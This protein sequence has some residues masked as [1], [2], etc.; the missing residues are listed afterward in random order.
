MSASGPECESFE[1]A[2]ARIVF[3]GELYNRAE[4]RRELDRSGHRCASGLAGEIILRSWRAWGDGCL[5]RFNGEWSFAI[6]DGLQ[7]RLICSRDRFGLRPFYYCLSNGYLIFGSDIGE[8]ASCPLVKKEPDPEAVFDYLAF[9]LI[10]RSDETF[11]RGVRELPAGCCLRMSSGRPPDVRRYYEPYCNLEIGEFDPAA[12]RGHATRLRELLESAVATRLTPPYPLGSLLSG[13]M[14]SSSIAC[15]AARADI[16]FFSILWEQEVPYID[17]IGRA[18]GLAHRR[19]PATDAAKLSWEDVAGAAQ[20]CARGPLRSSTFFGEMMIL[21]E[22]AR[23]GVRV[24]FDGSGGDELLA[25]YPDRY[26]RAFLKQILLSRDPAWF[27]KE[28]RIFCSSG[29]TEFGHR[30]EGGRAGAQALN[31]FLRAPSEAQKVLTDF[32][33]LPP[34]TFNGR[35]YRRYA[36]REPWTSAST[37]NIQEALRTD[38]FDI[39]KTL[40]SIGT[41]TYRRPFL[42]HRVVEHVLSLPACYKLHDG[43]TKYLL[44]LAMSD[45][46]PK[47]GCWRREKV[48]GTVPADVW[49]DFLRRHKDALRAVLSG[50]EF[51]SEAFL[52]QKMVLERFDNFFETAVAPRTRPISWLWRFVNLELWLRFNFP[53]RGQ[54]AS[55]DPA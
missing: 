54:A 31:A 55:M 45:I 10:G 34:E 26:F 46:M 9:N 7:G 33:L 12:A 27:M 2:G 40:H 51:H 32:R 8:I 25:G 6:W 20:R 42:D 24:F 28:W 4:L 53:G 5:E 29:V 30:R 15:L 23:R 38:T 11:Y 50:R 52:D 16:E 17:R 13:G 41:M 37:T 36:A 47:E 49:K 1:H 14:D 35:F 21:K 18:L 43:W 39:G 48:G 3:E 44:R 22:A 19:I